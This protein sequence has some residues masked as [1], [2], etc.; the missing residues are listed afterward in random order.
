MA[1]RAWPGKPSYKLS[2]LSKEGNLS[3]A[4]DHRALGDCQRTMI[5][6][7]AAASHLGTYR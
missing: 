2:E 1:Q 7:A 4:E 6:Y 3:L 5:V